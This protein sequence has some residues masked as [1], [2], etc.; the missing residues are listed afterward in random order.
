[1]FATFLRRIFCIP[2]SCLKIKN[3]KIAVCKKI[4]LSVLYRCGNV[5]PNLRDNTELGY[6]IT[7]ASE[8]CSELEE[9]EWRKLCN[10]EPHICAFYQIT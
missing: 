8:D 10:R 9:A 4:V 5:S 3:I 2:V 7:G 6:M 1:M